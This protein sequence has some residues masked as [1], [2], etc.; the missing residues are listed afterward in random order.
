VGGRRG[1]SLLEIFYWGR[2]LK[3]EFC[4]RSL[5]YLVLKG[6]GTYLMKVVPSRLFLAGLEI[7]RMLYFKK[8]EKC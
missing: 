4:S 3:D 1:V 7:A 6:V 2:A 8:N 5:Y